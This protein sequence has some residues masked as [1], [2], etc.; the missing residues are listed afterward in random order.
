MFEP[1]VYEVY[2]IWAHPVDFSG[3]LAAFEESRCWSP[4][5]AAWVWDSRD[6]DI[7]PINKPFTTFSWPINSQ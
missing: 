7:F 4:F 1:G 3:A 5:D 6:D 2:R